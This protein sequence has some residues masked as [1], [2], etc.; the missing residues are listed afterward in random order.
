M[1]DP[2]ALAEL[3]AIASAIDAELNK[4]VKPPRVG[5]ILLAFPFNRDDSRITYISNAERADV[6]TALRELVAR[7]EGRMIDHPKGELQ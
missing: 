2:R 3:Q 7:F 4:G 1:I 5:F 6:I